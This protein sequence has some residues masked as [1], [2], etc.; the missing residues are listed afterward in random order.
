MKILITSKQKRIYRIAKKLCD[1]NKEIEKVLQEKIIA[2]LH[3]DITYKFD[4]I[5]REH[6]L[7]KEKKELLTQIEN[8]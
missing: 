2:M 1:I 5:S 7:E 8:L 3:S 4:I 6:S